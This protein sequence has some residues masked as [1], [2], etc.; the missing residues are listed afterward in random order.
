M[1]ALK[2]IFTIGIISMIIFFLGSAIYLNWTTEKKLSEL[3]ASV[4]LADKKKDFY[5]N[6]T[7]SIE[8]LNANLETQIALEKDRALQLE[9]QR[10]L[11]ALQTAIRQ[12]QV[13]N[14]EKMLLDLQAKA[15]AEK[16]KLAQ[17]QQEQALKLAKASAASVVSTKSTSSSKPK[18]APVTKAS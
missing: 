9:L 2:T 15:E 6:T 4:S 18:P 3:Q 13:A 7:I 5:S 16:A 8:Q 17:L 12:K 1:K 14:N 10:N 11:T